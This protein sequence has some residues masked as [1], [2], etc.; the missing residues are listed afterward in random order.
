MLFGRAK[1]SLTGVSANNHYEVCSPSG[2]HYL[3][4]IFGIEVG[5][6]HFVVGCVLY[7]GK[8]QPL[9]P[10]L[11]RPP[12][13]SC[14]SAVLLVRR[15]RV[16]EYVVV[17]QRVQTVV[18]AQGS[19]PVTGCN[20]PVI[21]SRCLIVALF[22]VGSSQLDRSIPGTSIE[23]Y[24]MYLSLEQGH[25]GAKTVCGSSNGRLWGRCYFG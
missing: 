12:L 1:A 13:V 5:I 8:W 16:L 18:I 3:S 6:V 15:T 14:R 2:E 25:T 17:V 24:L 23:T 19:I 7:S 20:M 10:S 4:L 9:E 21:S 22:Y 11:L